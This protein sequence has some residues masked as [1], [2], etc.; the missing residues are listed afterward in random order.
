MPLHP[1]SFIRKE[2]YDTSNLY[3]KNY[4]IASDFDFFIGPYLLK[5]WSI[6]F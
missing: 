2:V 4:K 5:D 1:A 6:K 3:N